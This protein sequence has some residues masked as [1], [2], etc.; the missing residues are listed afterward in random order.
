M[1]VAQKMQ[2]D[3]IETQALKKFQACSFVYKPG[4]RE[5]DTLTRTSSQESRRQDLKGQIQHQCV[6]IA[7][8]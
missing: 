6:Q 4:F 2:T 3:H 5:P 7:P 8:K 1:D